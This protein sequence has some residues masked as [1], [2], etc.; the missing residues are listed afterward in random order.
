MQYGVHPCLNDLREFIELLEARGQLARIAT[1]VSR[2]LEITEIADRVSKGAQVSNKAL[3]FEH[4]DDFDMPVAINLF[5]SRQ[6]MSWALDVDDLDVL[7]QRLAALLDLKLPQG[8]GGMI[9][10]GQDL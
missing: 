3:V 4:V 5:G 7:N 10:R 9:D 1:P 6:R 2:D 8:L